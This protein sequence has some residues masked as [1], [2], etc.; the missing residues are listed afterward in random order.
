MHK[1]SFLRK[2][3]LI[4]VGILAVLALAA[5][6]FFRL[7]Q[8]GGSCLEIRVDDQVYGRYSLTEDQEIDLAGEG[9]ANLASIKDG[10]ATMV[11]ADCPDQICVHHKAIDKDGETI[12]CLPHKIVLEVI[13]EDGQNKQDYDIIVK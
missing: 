4:L 7:Q 1:N 12:I 5:F 13:D 8:T 11:K 2:N 9:Y 3:D 6:L 10:K